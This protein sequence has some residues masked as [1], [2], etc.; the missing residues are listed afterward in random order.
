MRRGIAEK[1]LDAGRARHRGER[2]E[3]EGYLASC[4]ALKNAVASALSKLPHHGYDFA[5]DF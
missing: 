1:L 4:L 2:I 5:L 3:D